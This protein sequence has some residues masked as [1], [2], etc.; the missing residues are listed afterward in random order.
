MSFLIATYLGI[1]VG[2]LILTWAVAVLAGRYFLQRRA[3][4]KALNVW[5]PFKPTLADSLDHSSPLS[6]ADAE[7]QLKHDLHKRAQQNGH[8]RQN[9]HYTESKKNL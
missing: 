9:G 1:V 3:R 7:E 6:E 8:Y 4:N 5:V 2:M